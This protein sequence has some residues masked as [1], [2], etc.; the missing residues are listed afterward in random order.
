MYAPH[1]DAIYNIQVLCN[2][3]YTFLIAQSFSLPIEYMLCKKTFFYRI[4]TYFLVLIYV[5]SSSANKTK[6][7]VQISVFL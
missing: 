7:E 2:K 1:I 4:P 6:K 5:H 3:I